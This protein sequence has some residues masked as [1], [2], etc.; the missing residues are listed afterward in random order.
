MSF[1]SAGQG[2][3]KGESAAAAGESAQSGAVGVSGSEGAGRERRGGGRGA[4]AGRRGG[5][6]RL[7]GRGRSR[8]GR[9]AR[10]VPE[11]RDERERESGGRRCSLLFALCACVRL[12]VGGLTLGRR[13]AA[14][15]GGR[16]APLR[17]FHAAQAG[18]V[19][20]LVAVQRAPSREGSRQGVPRGRHA[21]Q[22]V[23]REAGRGGP[24]AAPPRQPAPC[25]PRGRGA[26]PHPRR[27]APHQR[28][29]AQRR[30]RRPN[31]AGLVAGA[32]G[33]AAATAAAAGSG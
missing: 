1:T 32:H 16:D 14:R 30:D 24:G 23:L 2:G 25:A 5:C 9:A 21:V 7:E 4:A 12:G 18:R 17:P 3:G 19:V 20:R 11:R 26:G 15:P 29:A 27:S 10:V 28:P 31:P 8:E 22:R 33:S 6:L 13:G